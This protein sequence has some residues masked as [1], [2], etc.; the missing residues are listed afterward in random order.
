MTAF[1]LITLDIQ[2]NSIQIGILA[3]F[4]IAS[5]VNLQKDTIDVQFAWKCPRPR[6]SDSFK[7]KANLTGFGSNHQTTLL[8]P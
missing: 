5:E 1:A 6:D 3:F 2:Y 4:F 8:D 7:G